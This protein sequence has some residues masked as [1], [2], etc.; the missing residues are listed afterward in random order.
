MRF[1]KAK[2]DATKLYKLENPNNFI[3]IRLEQ[4]MIKSV[5]KVT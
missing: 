1:V 5:S 4:T 2:H 3:R